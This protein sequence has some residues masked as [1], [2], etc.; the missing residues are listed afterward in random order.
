M[1]S[2][3]KHRLSAILNPTSKVGNR[4][5]CAGEKHQIRNPR[6]KKEKPSLLRKKTPWLKKGQFRYHPWGPNVN[7]ID[8]NASQAT[9]RPH[10]PPQRHLLS[11]ATAHHGARPVR[12]PPEKPE[13]RRPF[14]RFGNFTTH[15]PKNKRRKKKEREKTQN[16][17]EGL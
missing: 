12:R 15:G 14:D 8:Q 1:P 3:P 5:P 7:F 11:Q 6:S 2:D 17:K 16:K 10:C 4:L 13:E 9:L